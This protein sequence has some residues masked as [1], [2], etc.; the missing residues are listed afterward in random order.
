VKT[1]LAILFTAL[2]AE[3]LLVQSAPPKDEPCP[4]KAIPK[5]ISVVCREIDTPDTPVGHPRELECV[6]RYGNEFNLI[7]PRGRQH[8]D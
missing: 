6:D 5:E 4:R 1:V 2:L 3:S 8:N 7:R